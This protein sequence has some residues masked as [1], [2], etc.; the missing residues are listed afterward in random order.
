MAFKENTRA[1]TPQLNGVA[2]RKNR[3]IAEVARA[4]LN[5]KNMPGCFWVEVVQ[6][7]VY[8]MNRM[9]TATVHIKTPKEMYSGQKPDV[10]HLNVFGCICY[11]HVPNEKRKKLDPK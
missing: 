8:I 6:C 9:P 3:S 4:L 7:A 11:V 1:H 5:E 2:K 10:S